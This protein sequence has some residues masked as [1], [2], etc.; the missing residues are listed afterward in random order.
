[1]LFLIRSVLNEHM[2]EISKVDLECRESLYF[3]LFFFFFF[4][5]FLFFFFF[6][7]I[8]IK[9][10]DN[11]QMYKMSSNLSQVGFFSW[12]LLYLECQNQCCL[13]NNFLYFYPIFTKLANKQ[14]M[15][16]ISEDFEFGPD[17]IIHFKVNRTWM[18]KWFFFFL[19]NNFFSYSSDIH[20]T[21]AKSLHA[22]NFR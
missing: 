8:F 16:N 7:P 3:T 9:L 12:E 22:L 21:Y 15:Q 6:N 19:I 14:H 11:Q 5:F 20:K 13:I 10:A 2:H 18:L 4:F 17:R 1:M